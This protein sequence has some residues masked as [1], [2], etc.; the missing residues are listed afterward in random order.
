MSDARSLDR[1]ENTHGRD[2]ILSDISGCREVG[3]GERNGRGRNE[4]E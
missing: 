2:R 1:L 3:Q 4:G